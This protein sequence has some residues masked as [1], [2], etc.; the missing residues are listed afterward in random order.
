MS[1]RVVVG[2]DK[3]NNKKINFSMH[4]QFAHQNNQCVDWICVRGKNSNLRFWV[5]VV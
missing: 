3:K 2:I 1:P 4:T 5:V